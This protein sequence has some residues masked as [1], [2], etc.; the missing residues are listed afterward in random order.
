MDPKNYLNSTFEES[1]RIQKAFMERCESRV[2]EAAQLM[3]QC[4]NSGGKVLICG[5]GGSASDAQHMAAEMVGRMLVDRRPLA[6]LALTTDSSNLTAIGNDFGFDHV[7]EMQV[8]GLARP[9]DLLIAISTSGSSPNVLK[10][11][12][13]ARSLDVK[14]LGITGKDGGRLKEVSDHCLIVEEGKNSSRIQ[15]THIFIL[16]SLVDLCDR[17]FLKKELL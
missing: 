8:K 14:V 3:A 7:F 10:A 12:E 6:A 5:N 2:I 13:A 16:H 9:G 15:E 1:Q 17:F 4:I 11:A